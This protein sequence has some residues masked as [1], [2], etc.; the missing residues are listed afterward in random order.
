MLTYGKRYYLVMDFVQ[1]FAGEAAL[2]EAKRRGQ[3]TPEFLM[4][5][6]NPRIRVAALT[7][8][9]RFSTANEAGYQVKCSRDDFL[10]TINT[11]W[12]N[13]RTSRASDPRYDSSEDLNY[14]WIVQLSEGNAVSVEQYSVP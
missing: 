14:V 1:M 9:T 11:Q 8:A 7:P 2:R 5:N 4:I 13:V 3:G 6:E 12:N 10:K